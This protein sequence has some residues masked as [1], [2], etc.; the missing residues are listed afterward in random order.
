VNR[1]LAYFG[2]GYAWLVL[3]VVFGIPLSLLLLFWGLQRI[4]FLPRQ[5]GDQN[6]KKCNYDLTGNVSGICPECGTPIPDDQKQLL[7]KG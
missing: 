3:F 7:A 6:C 5:C 2:P 1:L 4:G